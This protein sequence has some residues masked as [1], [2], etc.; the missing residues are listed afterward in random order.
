MNND[1]GY[2]IPQRPP[3]VMISEMIT[4]DETHTVTSFTIQPGNLFINN[5]VFSESGLVENMAQTA[6]A[7][8]R[9]IKEQKGQPAPLGYIAALKHVNIISL[10][11]VSDTIITE[12]TFI[13]TLLGFHLVKGKVTL[14]ET[15]IA[16][17][18]F[19]IFVTTDQ[20]AA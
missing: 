17:C 11:K 6:G 13:Q 14:G 8:T 19:K 10:P 3:F 9:F 2:Y 20:P 16:N 7:G 5:G 18:E 4:A 1:A 15:E 12:T